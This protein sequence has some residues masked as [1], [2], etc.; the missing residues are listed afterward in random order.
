[1]TSTTT[2]TNHGPQTTTVWSNGSALYMYLPEDPTIHDATGVPFMNI[3]SSAGSP[4]QL[5]GVSYASS[6]CVTVS[7]DPLP[8]GVSP[9]SD[10]YFLSSVVLI[11]FLVIS[12]VSMLVFKL[13][14]E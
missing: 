3:G 13:T 12:L 7:D 4:A 10:W 9:Y 11:A 8:A 1:M 2:C 14:Y 5:G 6:T